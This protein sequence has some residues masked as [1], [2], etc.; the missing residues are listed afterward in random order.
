MYI[1][2]LVLVYVPLH[3]DMPITF[4]EFPHYETKKACEDDKKLLDANIRV[5]KHFARCFERP[6]PR[7]KSS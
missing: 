6:I 7:A 1:Y 4:K 3:A 2:I 5:G